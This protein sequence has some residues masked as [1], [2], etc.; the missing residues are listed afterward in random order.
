M[1]RDEKSGRYYDDPLHDRGQAPE[2]N[3]GDLP[4]RPERESAHQTLYISD[5]IPKDDPVE[6]DF[7]K[8][9][10]S[11]EL[12]SLLSGDLTSTGSFNLMAIDGTWFGQLLHSMPIPALIVDEAFAVV[13]VNRAAARIGR[14]Y[15]AIQHKPFVSLF[16]NVWVGRE[17]QSLLEM[18]F[19]TRTPQVT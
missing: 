3:S 12:D 8:A 11:I 18:V 5:P 4:R 7:F 9:T 14:D 17:C 1:K 15:E 19:S 10:Q 16:A 2:P 6:P 13:F